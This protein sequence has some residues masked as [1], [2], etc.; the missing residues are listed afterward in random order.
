VRLLQ[1]HDGRRQGIPAAKRSR[2]SATHGWPE[3]VIRY[4][5]QQQHLPDQAL[6]WR[7]KG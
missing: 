7:A 4:M 1:P 3:L 2:R 6:D 5:Q